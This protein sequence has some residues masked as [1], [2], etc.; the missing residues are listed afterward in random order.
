[1]K[2]NLEKQ[3]NPL[4]DSEK[5][6]FDSKLDTNVNL[7]YIKSCNKRFIDNPD[8]NEC[9]TWIKGY[10]N[11]DR[12]DVFSKNC[13]K[14]QEQWKGK[15]GIYTKDDDNTIYMS[16]LT[17]WYFDLIN[18]EKILRCILNSGEILLEVNYSYNDFGDKVP[19][20]ATPNQTKLSNLLEN[21]RKDRSA[22]IE[23]LIMELTNSDENN[24]GQGN[25]TVDDDLSDVDDYYLEYAKS[26]RADR[27]FFYFSRLRDLS[28]YI[29]NS[30]QKEYDQY[31]PENI[32][33]IRTEVINYDN[34]TQNTNGQ[35]FQSQSMQKA[36]NDIEEQR[37]ILDHPLTKFYANNA[38]IEK[39]KKAI[40][41]IKE[42][43]KRQYQKFIFAYML[44]HPDEIYKLRNV[45]KNFGS[46]VQFK[47]IE[48]LLKHTKHKNFAYACYEFD[49]LLKRQ[50]WLF[51][52]E[53]QSAK[54]KLKDYYK[55]NI[56]NLGCNT[57]KVVNSLLSDDQKT[58]L[59]KHICT[60]CV[61]FWVTL[62]ILVTVIIA[63]IPIQLIIDFIFFLCFLGKNPITAGLIY[64]STAFAAIFWIAVAAF[65]IAIIFW[66]Y[67]QYM[68]Y[69]FKKS[70][71]RPPEEKDSSQELS[72]DISKENDKFGDLNNSKDN[73]NFPLFSDLD[74][75]VEVSSNVKYKY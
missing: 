17:A 32:S 2:E 27:Y 34:D 5:L 50:L 16:C 15:F 39:I 57:L 58:F 64:S 31:N 55:T 14:S 10:V 20:S 71:K 21:T 38:Q 47:F 7:T 46:S 28:E 45:I 73:N 36:Q 72:H 19:H 74:S 30:V 9:T 56:E 43:Y 41:K 22:E 26:E 69:R 63:P 4:N 52:K 12:Q 70:L 23:K 54:D 24:N 29:D 67:K 49:D 1:M 6:T 51:E 68:H 65:A 61:L 25:K 66:A 62:E 60:S 59:E 53:D 18:Y 35:P 75:S 37:K 11:Q 42:G 33:K 13:F 8:K 40:D 44:E 3:G 48:F